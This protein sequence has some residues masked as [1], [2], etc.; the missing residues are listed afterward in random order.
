MENKDKLKEAMFQ[1]A[2]KLKVV[3][4]LLLLVLFLA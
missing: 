4:F 1:I 3:C 2:E